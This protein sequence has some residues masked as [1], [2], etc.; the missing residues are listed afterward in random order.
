MSSYLRVDAWPIN[1]QRTELTDDG[2]CINS[3]CNMTKF[4]NVSWSY[5]CRILLLHRKI[6]Y[7]CYISNNFVLTMI[8]GSLLSEL[9]IVWP[10]YEI[11]Q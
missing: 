7:C 2:L 8:F 11:V 1:I 3:S 6:S 10:E 4:L 5:F 9:M